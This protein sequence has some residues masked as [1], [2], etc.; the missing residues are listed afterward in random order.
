[1]NS[2]ATVSSNGNSVSEVSTSK[3][4]QVT[5]RTGDQSWSV[6][7]AVSLKLAADTFTDPQKQALT[8]TATQSDGSAL[9]SWLSFNA[10]TETFS[11]TVPT[12]TQSFGIKVTA[13]DTG[14][15]STSEV[16]GV[17]LPNPKPPQVTDRTGDQSWSVG[18]AVN[19]KLAADTFTDPQKQA[20]TYAATL[21]DGSAL[22]SWLSFNAGTETFSGTVPTGTGNFVIKVT[23]TDTGGLSASE[24]IGV[25]LPSPKPPQ[26]TDQTA[27][28]SWTVGQTIN[29]KLA[30][31]TFTDPQKQ[32]LTYAAT[33]TD[34]SALPSWLTFNASTETFSG[35]VPSTATGKLVLVVSA[36][37]SG[38][39]KAAEKF[40]ATISASHASATA[41][42]P[43]DSHVDLVPLVGIHSA[44]VIDAIG[45]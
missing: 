26:V 2:A 45:Q 38:N 13:T 36:T 32:A 3:P 35:T 8:Y 34:G 24:V 41:G 25:K 6:G 11:G 42:N 40:T 4:P 19:L 14:G 20:L 9:P 7:Q 28:Q 16:F 29:L 22:P 33:Q 5:D 15:L 39:L 44:H 12:G 31:D 21:A 1:M 17:R 30:A 27:N 43:T 23:A 18:Q 10:S 37:D